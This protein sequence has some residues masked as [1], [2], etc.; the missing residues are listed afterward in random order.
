MD[1]QRAEFLTSM[2]DILE[3]LNQTCVQRGEPLLASV[4]AIAKGEAEDA[5][6]HAEELKALHKMRAEMTSRTSW[7]AEEEKRFFGDAYEPV[8]SAEPGAG[9]A[10]ADALE[11]EEQPYDEYE[12][13]DE[14]AA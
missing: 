7:R 1:A 10:E 9:A 2:I 13:D 8:A 11:V 4:L 6:R 12:R 14:I 5:L 3:R